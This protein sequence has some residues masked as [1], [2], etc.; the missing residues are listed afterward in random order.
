MDVSIIIVNWNT[1]DVLR[2]CLESI[3]D[4]TNNI[5]FEVI[6]VDNASSDDSVSILKANFPGVKLIA[7]DRN[8]G[9]AAA[10]NQAMVV[11]K[12]RYILLLNP[13]TIILDNAIAKSVIFADYHVNAGVLGV[14][15]LNVD[16]TLQPSCFMLPSLLNMFL[17]STYLYKLL[18]QS[19]FFGR[20][21]MTWWDRNDVREVEVVTGCFMLVRHEVIEQVG[22]MDERFFMYAEETDWC[23]RIK[24]A[25]WK[26]M[27]TPCGQIIH[28]GGVSSRQMKMEME[29]QKRA[30]ILFYY[31][32]HKNLFS[33]GLACLLVSI[34]FSLRA[35]FWF[36]IAVT[37]KK[38]RNLSLQ[39]GRAYAIGAVKALCGWQMLCFKK[40]Y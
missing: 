23:Y 5:E 32:K 20:E 14:K 1:K 33:Y 25:G 35:P 27:F 6:V 18:P 39:R 3:Y 17:S 24:Q 31:K 9:F 7:N 28:L 40:K 37:S 34:F 12:G 30:S 22:M 26:I 13:D 10:N 36:M 38:Q 19:K 11:A 8:R 4:Q 16:D 29:M 21:Q 2:N 15:I